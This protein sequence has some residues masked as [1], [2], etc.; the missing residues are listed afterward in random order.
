MR[1]LSFILTFVILLVLSLMSERNLHRPRST[2]SIERLLI[3][4]DQHQQDSCYEALTCEDKI[5]LSQLIHE[6]QQLPKNIS[7]KAALIYL[8]HFLQEYMQ[9]IQILDYNGFVLILRENAN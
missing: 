5:L 2:S 8:N 9:N 3:I 7:A 1:L 4:K 6:S